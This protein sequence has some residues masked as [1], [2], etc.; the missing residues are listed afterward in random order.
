MATK[1]NT[2]VLRGDKEYNYFRITRTVGHEW[3][4]GKKI[5]ISM[6]PARE[7][8]KNSSVLTRKSSC[9]KNMK[10]SML[11]LKPNGRP[12]ENM[13]KNIPTKSS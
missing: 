1:K 3:K 10:R 11:Q 4:D 12:L 2:A 9:R 6:V 7:M 13:Q 5:P 8:R